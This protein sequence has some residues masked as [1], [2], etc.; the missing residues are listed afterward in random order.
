MCIRDRF[1][2]WG[3]PSPTEVNYQTCGGAPYL[4]KLNLQNQA[5]RD[6]ILRVGAFWVEA[7]IDGWRIDVA[8][9]VPVDFWSEFRDAIRVVNSDAYLVAEIW[10]DA[11]PWLEAFD[12]AMNYQQ[13]AA[14]LD[15]CTVSYT[16]LR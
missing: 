3:E 10:R 12:G 13:R 11:T 5:L 6:H 7:G 16:H 9:K 1:T 4:P 14:I 2:T 15:F 8:W